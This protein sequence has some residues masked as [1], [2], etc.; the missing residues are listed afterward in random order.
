MF[1]RLS[2]LAI[3][4]VALVLSHDLTFFARYGSRYGEALAHA[5]HGDAWT[6]AVIGVLVGGTILAV[7]AGV[8]LRRLAGRAAASSRR[9]GAAPG[10][11]ADVVRMSLRTWAWLAPTVLALL[12]VQENLERLWS[13]GAAPR[14]GILAS[15]EYAGGWAIVLAVTAAVATVAGL[16]RWRRATVLARLRV[17]M[18]TRQRA[19]SVPRPP[20][21]SRIPA[22]SLI[23]SGRALR[24]PP[25]PVAI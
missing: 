5:G 9:E 6:R 25:R 18:P 10:G 7:A 4:L 21:T 19:R 13:T 22:G 3:T 17:A 11:L 14:L 1:R 16:Y 20:H 12:T 24:A 2:G 15:P 8:S 23:G